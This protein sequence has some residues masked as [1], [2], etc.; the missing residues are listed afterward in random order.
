MVDIESSGFLLMS[1]LIA[2][3]CGLASRLA[4]V[5]AAGTV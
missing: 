1:R 4:K 5:G 2:A 3:Y